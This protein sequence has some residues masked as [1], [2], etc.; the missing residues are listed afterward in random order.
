[1]GWLSRRKKPPAVEEWQ[2]PQWPAD[3]VELSPLARIQ[4]IAATVTDGTTARREDLRPLTVK[5]IREVED[6]QPASLSEAYRSFLSVMGG[7]AGRLFRGS[8]VYHPDVMG[9][10]QAAQELLAENGSPFELATSDRVFFMHQGYQ[11]WFLRGSDPDPE[12]WA[13]N[14]GSNGDVPLREEACFT[15]WLRDVAQGEMQ[16]WA[17][18][19]PWYEAQRKTGMVTFQRIHPDGSVTEEF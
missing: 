12:V 7:G 18:L 13:Y 8:D 6:D 5:V 15:D 3:W 2:A 19:V 11:F 1:M 17:H 10:W 4:A 16:Q 9:L 14:E